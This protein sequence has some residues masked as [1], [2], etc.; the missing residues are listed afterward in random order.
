MAHF[1]PNSVPLCNSQR[2]RLGI[3]LQRHGQATID[4]RSNHPLWKLRT[5]LERWEALLLANP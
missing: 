3:H 5:R 1:T 4:V 2:L